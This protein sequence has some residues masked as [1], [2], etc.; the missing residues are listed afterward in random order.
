MS[1]KV[2]KLL[3]ELISKQEDNKA[4]KT[5]Q[6][7]IGKITT[8]RGRQIITAGGRGEKII[9]KASINCPRYRSAKV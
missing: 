1:D 6:G 4:T 2:T 9:E 3:N 8:E 5:V 7:Y